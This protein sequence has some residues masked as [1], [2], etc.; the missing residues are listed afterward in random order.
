LWFVSS[1][2]SKKKIKGNKLDSGISLIPLAPLSSL[3]SCLVLE[4]EKQRMGR[5]KGWEKED[6]TKEQRQ[7]QN[8]NLLYE[9]NISLISK[10]IQDKI[11]I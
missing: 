2:C 11:N 3:L 6:P 8:P 4:G 7:L 5:H 9:A 1:L 10:P